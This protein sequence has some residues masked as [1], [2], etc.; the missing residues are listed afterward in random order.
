M[1]D[2]DYDS[3]GNLKSGP[4]VGSGTFTYTYRADNMM[5]GAT[6]G[7]TVT[8]FAYDGGASRIKKTTGGV[9]TY[10]LRGPD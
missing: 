9:P 3:N 7:S 5:S 2:F 8:G 6:V 10:F 1:T 4:A